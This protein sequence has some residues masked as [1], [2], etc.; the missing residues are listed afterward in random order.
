MAFISLYS[1]KKNLEKSALKSVF[2]VLEIKTAFRSGLQISALQ[3]LWDCELRVKT[4]LNFCYIFPSLKSK[5]S[6]L[7]CLGMEGLW[8]LEGLKLEPLMHIY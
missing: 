6:V 7:G 5:F 2:V 3:Y 8:L 4:A 1:P